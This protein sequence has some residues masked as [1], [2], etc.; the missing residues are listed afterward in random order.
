MAM[1]EKNTYKIFATLAFDA[2]KWLYTRTI[3]KN[4]LI[5]RHL[6][7]TA[8]ISQAQNQFSHHAANGIKFLVMLRY[9][10]RP[11][12]IFFQSDAQIG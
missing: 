9:I 11:L 4:L 7:P 6:I 5:R 10:W 2:K 8:C 1:T 12:V 3:R